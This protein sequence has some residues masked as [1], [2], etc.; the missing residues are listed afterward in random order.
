MATDQVKPILDALANLKKELETKLDALK[1]DIKDI[2]QQ[3]NKVQDYL[4]RKLK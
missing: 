2:E 1:K 4:Q 3:L